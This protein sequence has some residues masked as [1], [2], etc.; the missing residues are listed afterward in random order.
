MITD[1]ET[2]FV[3]LSEW[4][5]TD[6]PEMVDILTSFFKEKLIHYNYLESTKDYY[7]RD[8]MPIQITKD[9]FVQFVFRPT[10][11]FKPKDFPYLSNPL[12][13]ELDNK[14]I[15]PHYS[16][17]ILDGGNVVKGKEKVI[18]TN[19]VIDDNIYQMSEVEIIKELETLLEAEIII[20]PA[21]KD[22]DTGHADGMI[23][24][25]D[26]NT[27][28]ISELYETDSILLKR[29]KKAGLKFEFL[30]LQSKRKH[31]YHWAYIN[32]LQT[33]DLILL[34]KFKLEEDDHA[35]SE[36]KRHY[37]VYANNDRI[38]QVDI[39]PIVKYDDAL[40]CI[41]WTIKKEL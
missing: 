20:I 12:R 21:L 39:S 24:F 41:S 30:R 5:K 25:I 9:K 23:R 17:L 37:P 27:V 2:N 31:K 1:Q 7:C 3:H 8:Y 36:I 18:I 19:K 38:A 28:L 32:F 29:L 10:T 34:P 22:D 35:L 16:K 40:N 14:L 33:K 4:T 26:E 6:F 15:Q 13:I 11:Y